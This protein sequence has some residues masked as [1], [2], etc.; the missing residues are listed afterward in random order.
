MSPTIE[1]VTAPNDEVRELVDE[2]NEALAGPYEPDQ[3]HGSR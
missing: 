1:Q 2:L 3:H